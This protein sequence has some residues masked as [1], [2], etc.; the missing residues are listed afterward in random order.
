VDELNMGMREILD[1]PVSKYIIRDFLMLE[2]SKNIV[3]AARLMKE[4]E[5][6]FIIVMED[7]KPAG[8]L[9]L[10]DIV[11]KVVSE[12][13]DP[14]RT[15]TG[16]ISSKPLL[17]VDSK[18]KV[19]EAIKLMIDNDIRR[20]PVIDSGTLLGVVVLR[21][22]FGHIVEKSIPLVELETPEGVSCPYCGSVFKSRE[23]LSKHIDRVHIG[24]GILEGAARRRE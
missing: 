12:G 11:Y 5:I 17:T 20:L 19:G 21:A 15:K 8:M 6:D 4:K 13:R 18:T 14:R 16:E 2:A 7:G 10:R 24:A 9:T 23:E 3:E 22:V 1:Q